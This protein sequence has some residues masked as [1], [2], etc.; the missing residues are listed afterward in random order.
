LTIW[1]YL[2]SFSGGAEIANIGK[3][4]YGKCKHKTGH[5][6]GMEKVSSTYCTCKYSL[7]RS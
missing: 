6:A 7:W 4:K 3:R 5:Y 2:H 1:V